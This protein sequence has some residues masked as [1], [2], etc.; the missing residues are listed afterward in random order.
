M[1]CHLVQWQYNVRRDTRMTPYEKLRGQ[2]CR[3]EI[4]PLEKRAPS[5]RPGADVHQLDQRWSTGLWLGG[6]MLDNEHLIC[7]A[8]V[9]SSRAVSQTPRFRSLGACSVGGNDS[10][11]VGDTSETSRTPSLAETCIG[12]ACCC[13]NIAKVQGILQQSQKQ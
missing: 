2:Q 8:G 7:T 10:H 6:D 1:W 5:R 13:W 9:M 12:G 3:S 4:L 11:S